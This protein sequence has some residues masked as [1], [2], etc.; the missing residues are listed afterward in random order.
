MVLI[1]YRGN[2]PKLGEVQEKD[3]NSQRGSQ[4]ESETSPEISVSPHTDT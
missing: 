3:G 1:I 4:G 2:R